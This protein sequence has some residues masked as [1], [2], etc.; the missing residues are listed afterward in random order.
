MTFISENIYEKEGLCFYSNQLCWVHYA[1]L[2][3]KKE[4]EREVKDRVGSNMKRHMKQKL[5]ML[6]SMSLEEE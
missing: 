3:I 1:L 6:K 4:T 2:K 5:G